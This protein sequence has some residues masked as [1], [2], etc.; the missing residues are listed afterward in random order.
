MRTQRNSTVARAAAGLAVLCAMSMSTAAC[1]GNAG[2]PTTIAAPVERVDVDPTLLQLPGNDSQYDVASSVMAAMAQAE[3]TVTGTVVGWQEGPAE[4]SDWQDGQGARSL[5]ALMEVAVDGSYG[6]EQAPSTVYVELWRGEDAVDESGAQ[7]PL[8][9]NRAY[10]VLPLDQLAQGAPAGARVVVIGTRV[11]VATASA[12]P[13]SATVLR[14][15]AQGLWFEDAD[16]SL[17][18][19]LLPPEDAFV[20]T[21][22]G[23]DSGGRATFAELV[24]EV[25]KG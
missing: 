19:G 11:P 1:A 15:I 7:V 5:T 13:D 3:Y 21:W 25:A 6:S 9:K 20:G 4:I 18:N 2:A 23:A 12:A 10:N 17:V 22:P 24:D 8:G 14:P 16:G